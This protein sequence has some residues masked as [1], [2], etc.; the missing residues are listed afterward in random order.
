MARAIEEGTLSEWTGRVN[1]AVAA[2]DP[3]LDWE[4]GAGAQSL[5]YFCVSA[6]GDMTLRIAAERWLQRAAQRTD[7]W[8]FYAAKPE[9]SGV[10][11]TTIGGQALPLDD[12]RV[13]CTRAGYRLEL[14]V[15]VFHPAWGELSE[16]DR[17]TACFVFLDT[18]LG[19]DDVE[20]W[21]GGVAA[22]LT[23]PDGAV[24]LT[25]LKAKIRELSETT[26]TG[27]IL[28]SETDAGHVVISSLDVS[29]K[30]IDH[31]GMDAHVQILI[32][33]SGSRDDG[34]CDDLDAEELNDLE[35]DLLEHLGPDAIYV[36]RR[37]FDFR[38]VLHFRAAVAGPVAARANS[39]ARRQPAAI[40][41]SVES[42]PKWE[43]MPW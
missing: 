26:E 13:S 6:G 2:V 24:M 39:W 5:H 12:A 21:L 17:G 30:R 1:N 3:E 10:V 36:G 19:E 33:F 7:T 27:M 18:T 4:F 32:P 38:R 20:R 37:T 14:D 28:E 23:E 15:E 43:S 35:D 25:E 34:L 8:E 41:V 42:D 29:I 31:L 9:S 16:N 40:E 22:V 11:K